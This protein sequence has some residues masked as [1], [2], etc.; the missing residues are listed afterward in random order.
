[1]GGKRESRDLVFSVGKVRCC[2]GS[3]G[4]QSEVPLTGFQFRHPRPLP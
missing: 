3:L 4:T 2:A 1:M